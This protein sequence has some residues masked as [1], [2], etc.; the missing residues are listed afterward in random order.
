MALKVLMLRNKLDARKKTLEGLR[1]AA[2]ELDKREKELETDVANAKTDEERA[3][4]DTAVT[5]FEAERTASDGEIRSVSDEITGLERELAAAEEEARSARSAPPAEPADG[6]AHN[7]RM[8]TTMGNETRDKI[9][10]MTLRERESFVQRDDVKDFCLRVR[11]FSAQK[12]T[13]TGAELGVP[14]VMLGILRDNINRYSK[15]IGRITVQP[16]KGQARQ[17]V[18]G[19][20]PEAIWTEAT[21]AL[22]ELDITFSQVEMDGFKVSGFL[23]VPNSTIEDDSDLQLVT[24]IMDMMGQAIGLAVD[25]AIIYGTGA[26]MPVGFITRLAAMAKPSWWGENQ[27]EFVDLHSSN[28]LKLDIFSLVGAQFFSALITALGIAKPNYSSSGTLTW[29]MN[30]KTHIDLM[31]KCLAFDLNAALVAGMNNT[32]PVIGGDIIEL[33]FIPDYDIAGGYLDLEKF[34]ERAGAKIGS[35]DQPLYIQDQTVYKATQRYDG[36]CLRGEAFVLLNYANK[37]PTTTVVFGNDYAN[38]DLGTLIVTTAAGTAVGTTKVT[39]AGNTAGAVLKYKV[40]GTPVSLNCG[41]KLSSKWSNLDTS[42]DIAATGGYIT[43]AE[44][45]SNNKVV[46]AGAGIVNAKASA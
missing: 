40:A 24:T 42:A 28:V 17:N 16:I 14:T 30:H 39:V 11:E 13:V 20:V 10:G 34:V 19:V 7:E 12:R 3:A 1:A 27:G 31:A 2:L 4:V 36:K 38:T 37:T 46:K 44:L 33:D 5:A 9:L 6:T 35:T 8:E 32:M 43:V 18:A 21:G 15:L 26:K 25:K 45:D 23:A 29:V 41:D 22:N